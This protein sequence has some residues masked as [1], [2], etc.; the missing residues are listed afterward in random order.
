MDNL[1][2]LFDKIEPLLPYCM[3]SMAKTEH[4]KSSILKVAEL[5]DKHGVPFRAFIN[6]LTDL[7]TWEASHTDV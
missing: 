6:I 1:K 5:C 3:A 2:Y 7:T 4:E